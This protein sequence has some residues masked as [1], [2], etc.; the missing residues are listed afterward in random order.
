MAKNE[1][2]YPIGGG[3]TSNQRFPGE[4]SSR[5][6]HLAKF[7]GWSRFEAQC[8]FFYEPFD[9]IDWMDYE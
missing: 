3:M 5:I 1:Q 6:E 2:S 9:P 7:Y 4:A 8:Y